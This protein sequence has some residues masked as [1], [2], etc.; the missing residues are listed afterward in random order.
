MRDKFLECTLF[1]RLWQ[2][3]H[4][5]LYN[6][7]AEE[8]RRFQVFQENLKLIQK[9]NDEHKCVLFMQYNSTISI[10]SGFKKTVFCCSGEAFFKA[11]KFAD[12]SPAEF[13]KTILMPLRPSPKHSADK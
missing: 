6:S 12:M 1:C 4:N 13:Q 9:L 3:E 7:E 10:T 2:L 8:S 5:K 11:N